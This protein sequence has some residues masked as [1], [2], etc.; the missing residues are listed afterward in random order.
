MADDAGL[1]C[2]EFVSIGVTVVGRILLPLLA[3]ASV[4]NR[5]L[6]STHLTRSNE[7]SKALH[8]YFVC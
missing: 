8:E 5:W 1:S 2:I 3:S 4:H 7:V 6:S